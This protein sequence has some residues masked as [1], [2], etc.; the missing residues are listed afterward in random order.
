MMDDEGF[1]Q[2]SLIDQLHHVYTSEI[3]RKWGGSL[4]QELRVQ[5]RLWI[6]FASIYYVRT[7]V[8]ACLRM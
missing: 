3:S 7:V 6:Y 4:V 5:Q 8:F 2:N 1:C